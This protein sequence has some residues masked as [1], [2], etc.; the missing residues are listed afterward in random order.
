[1]DREF[2][3]KLLED[4]KLKIDKALETILNLPKV[5]RFHKILVQRRIDKYISSIENEIEQLKDEDEDGNAKKIES[6]E[7]KI[8]RVRA[9]EYVT[10][11]EQEFNKPLNLN[12]VI[13]LPALMYEKEGFNFGVLKN[14]DAGKPSTDEETLT[15][16]RLTIKDPTKPKAVFLDSLLEMK[17]L[18]KMYTTFIK[19]WNEEVQDDNCLHGKFNIIGTTSGRLSCI[20]GDSL[21]LTQH[22]YLSL[23]DIK[24]SGGSEICTMTKEGWKPITQFIYKGVDEMYEVELEDGTKIQ[25][26]LDHKF[27]TNHGTRKLREIFNKDRNTINNKYKLLKYVE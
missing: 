25:C 22:G 7:Q 18:Q 17:G 4:Y 23:E 26:T 2:N 3:N 27:I 8:A 9:G 12:S 19:G 14:T 5:K 11:T 13:E 15:N 10:K 21:I 16:L 20:S 1:M 24:N 6:R